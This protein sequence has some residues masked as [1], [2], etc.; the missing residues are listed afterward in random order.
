MEEQFEV[1]D[2]YKNKIKY[3]HM[4]FHLH[5]VLGKL[6]EEVFSL[7]KITR[8][9]GITKDVF[10]E[11]MLQNYRFHVVRSHNVTYDFSVAN[12]SLMKLHDL[13]LA[14]LTMKSVDVS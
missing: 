4:R 6:E 10:L 1:A 14:V 5:V 11:G 3:G 2:K 12:F 13:L 9:L 7:M 8:V